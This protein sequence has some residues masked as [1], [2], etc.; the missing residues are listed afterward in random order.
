MNNKPFSEIFQERVDDIYRRAKDA[1]VSIAALCRGAGTARTTPDR[2][3]TRLP[4]TV[5]LVDDLEAELAK[6]EQKAPPAGN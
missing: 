1:G 5:T 2:W 4:M 6:H 3:R